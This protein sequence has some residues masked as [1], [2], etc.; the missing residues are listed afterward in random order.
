MRTKTN[1]RTIALGREIDET[2]AAAYFGPLVWVEWGQ[3]AVGE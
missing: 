3:L 2:W 1:T